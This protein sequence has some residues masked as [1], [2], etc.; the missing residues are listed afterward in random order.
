MDGDRPIAAGGDPAVTGMAITMGIAMGITVAIVLDIVLDIMQGIV[1]QI[2]EQHHTHTGTCPPIMYIKI[3]LR[4]L[5]EPGTIDMM[6]RQVTRLQQLIVEGPIHSRP[7][8]PTMFIQTGTE[9][10]T[11]RKATTGTG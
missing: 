1:T 6:Q 2:Q 7:T 8:R 4:G 5:Q 9:M 10:Y 3:V 11:A